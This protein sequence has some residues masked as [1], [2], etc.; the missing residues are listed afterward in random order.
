MIGPVLPSAGALRPLGVDEVRLTDGFWAERVSRNAAATLPHCLHWIERTGWLRN[1]RLATAGG[2]DAGRQGREFSDS[3]IYKLAEAMAWETARSGTGV[4]GLDGIAEAVLAAQHADGYLNTRFG[5][6]GQRPRYSDLE[7]GHELYCYGHLIQAGVA[8]L[9]AGTAEAVGIAAIRVADHVSAEFGVDGRTGICGHPE[10]EPALVELYRVTGERRYLDQARLFVER[11][12]RGSL[13]DIA[14]GRVYYQ[15]DL[16]VRGR[17][18]FAGHAVRELYLAAGAVDVAVETGDDKLLAAVIRQW[19]R[20]VA[21]RTYL[22]GGMG[23]RYDGESFGEDF[24]LP[25]DGAYAETC[26]AVASV[27]L[28]WRLLLATGEGRFADL[29]ERTLYNVVAT[30]TALSGRAFFY[31]NTLHQRVP[32]TLP[33]PDAPSPYPVGSV[34]APWREVSCCPT[35]ISRLLASLGGY[36]ATTDDRG[37]QLH[38][39]VG[40]EIRTGAV[41]LTVRTDYPWRGAVAVRVTEPGDGPWRLALRVPSWAGAATLVTPDGVRQV[42]AGG[43]AEVE[44]HW[45][46]GD[47]V[48]LELP[49]QARWT[50]PDPRI[51]AV[52]GSV[53]VERGPLV[54]C[55]ESVEQAPVLSLDSVTVDPATT[56]VERPMPGLGP[57]AVGLDV[58]ASVAVA[59]ESEWPYGRA[60]VGERQPVGL[61][62]LP[63]HLRANRGPASMRVW[64]PTEPTGDAGAGR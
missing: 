42:P 51:D 30:S 12:G 26:A 2:L 40:A 17:T 54:Y 55:A 23:S 4:A 58:P 31:A 38:Q 33:D 16:P 28:C 59:P 15:D 57:D 50:V 14:L 41:G 62:L 24:E 35:N 45:R 25:P 8:A 29:A 6:P 37:V 7:W 46:A 18:V 49:M 5:Q 20:T 64:L 39:F 52:R 44:R 3:E 48:C 10:I 21:A 13:A 34:R 53:A 43:Y 47:E 60:P 22:T 36:V 61:A 63:Y 9:R 19:E 32:G 1:F 56:P 11:R 27:M